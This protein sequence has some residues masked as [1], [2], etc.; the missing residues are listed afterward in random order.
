MVNKALAF[1]CI[2]LRQLKNNYIVLKG[3]PIH[4]ISGRAVTGTPGE[5]IQLPDYDL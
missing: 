2:I 1:I 3:Y 5:F 4:A